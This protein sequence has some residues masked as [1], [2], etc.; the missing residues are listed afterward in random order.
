MLAP[1]LKK[2]IFVRKF[3]IVDGAINVLNSSQVMLPSSFIDKLDQKS[4][5]L[6]SKEL[7]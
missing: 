5:S 7:Y 3:K 2:L 1:I 4:S 6:L